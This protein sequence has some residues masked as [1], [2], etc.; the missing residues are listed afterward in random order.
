[1]TRWRR[2]ASSVWR[3]AWGGAKFGRE[4]GGIY[5]WRFCK[6]ASKQIG[7]NFNGEVVIYLNFKIGLW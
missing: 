7:E 4:A 5:K 6:Y 2:V 1:M 3:A